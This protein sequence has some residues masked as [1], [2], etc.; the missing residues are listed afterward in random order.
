MGVQIVAWIKETIVAGLEPPNV[1]A[2][3]A[4]KKSSKPLVD[5]GQLLN[6]IH[7]EVVEV[8]QRALTAPG[9]AAA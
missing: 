5:H 1:P 9:S 2:T 8:A 6:S 3:I 7:F 4:R